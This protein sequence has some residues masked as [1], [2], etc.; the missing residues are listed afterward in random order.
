VW[1]QLTVDS[2]SGKGRRYLPTKDEK[3]ERSVEADDSFEYRGKLWVCVLTS[4]LPSSPSLLAVLVADKDLMRV[5]SPDGLYLRGMVL[6][7]PS[8]SF[9]PPLVWATLGRARDQRTLCEGSLSLT[10]QLV[11]HA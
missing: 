3:V 7:R 10:L 11:S 6:L 8:Q 4:S 5:K 9:P 1:S 2:Y